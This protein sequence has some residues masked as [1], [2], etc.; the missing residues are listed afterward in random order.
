MISAVFGVDGLWTRFCGCG[1]L[2]MSWETITIR[3]LERPNRRRSRLWCQSERSRRHWWNG[4]SVWDNFQRFRGMTSEKSGM[5][6]P[7]DR[8]MKSYDIDSATWLRWTARQHT[9]HRRYTNKTAE[10]T[11]K[12]NCDDNSFSKLWLRRIREKRWKRFLFLFE[13]YKLLSRLLGVYWTIDG[14]IIICCCLNASQ[15][16]NKTLIAHKMNTF[17]WALSRTCQ[18]WFRN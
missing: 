11:T 7:Y 12:R 17:V 10:T 13:I 2:K 4:K 15:E 6:M 1:D 9:V 16:H 8:T 18:L 3:S 5:C 14:L